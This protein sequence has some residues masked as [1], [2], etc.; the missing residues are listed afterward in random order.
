MKFIENTV[1]LQN[2][3]YENEVRCYPSDLFIPFPCISLTSKHKYAYMSKNHIFVKRTKHFFLPSGVAS[4]T[5]GMFLPMM[6]NYILET[7]TTRK[8]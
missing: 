8:H 1:D 5:L 4:K 3:R 2:E 6:S 7:K